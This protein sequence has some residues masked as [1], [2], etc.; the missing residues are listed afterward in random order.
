MKEALVL[1]STNLIPIIILQADHGPGSL[2]DIT[3]ALNTCLAARFS[4]FSTYYLPGVNPWV[5]P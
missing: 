5:V 4:T 3:S 2:T 1:N